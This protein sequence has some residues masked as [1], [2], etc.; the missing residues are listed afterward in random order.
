MTQI[1]RGWIPTI[2]GRLSFS[3]IGSGQLDQKQN[4][5]YKCIDDVCY[6]VVVQM[7]RTSDAPLKIFDKLYNQTPHFVFILITESH[8]PFHECHGSVWVID[9]KKYQDM[10]GYFQKCSQPQSNNS[11]CDNLSEIKKKLDQNDEISKSKSAVLIRRDGLCEIKLEETAD[12][13]EVVANQVYYFLKDAAHTHQHHE[14]KSETILKSYKYSEKDKIHWKRE[15]IYALYRWVIQQKRNKDVICYYNA[16]GVISYAESFKELH[17]SNEDSSELKYNATHTVQSLKNSAKS[18]QSED[19]NTILTT[20]GAV[21]A[22]LF[23]VLIAI[24]A[25]IS[26]KETTSESFQVEAFQNLLKWVYYNP[27]LTI[28]ASLGLIFINESW[29]KR[30]AIYTIMNDY[31]RIILAVGYWPAFG[32]MLTLSILST[33]IFLKVVTG[34]DEHFLHSVVGLVSVGVLIPFVKKINTPLRSKIILWPLDFVYYLLLLLLFALT[35]YIIGISVT[36][37]LISKPG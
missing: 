13:A 37:L 14:D 4:H 2:T 20:V 36:D 24:Y 8:A 12:T 23:G 9:I 29:K 10:R 26:N 1:Y 28:A 31:M 11:F 6:T 17:L 5:V 18:L 34:I 15:T 3:A 7:R 19:R 16:M 25:A 22:P 35:G 27:L 33:L 21:L 30:R 32:L